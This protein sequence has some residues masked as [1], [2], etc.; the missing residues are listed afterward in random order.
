[1]KTT[2]RQLFVALVMVSLAA[3]LWANGWVNGALAKKAVTIKDQ[4]GIIETG[5][6]QGPVSTALTADFAQPYETSPVCVISAI[7]STIGFD[8]T[9]TQRFSVSM[10][11]VTSEGVTVFIDNPYPSIEYA[12]IH[13]RCVG[14]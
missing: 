7:P 14:Q 1:M 13:W 5:Q 4:Y 10:M 12:E 11:Q 2:R 8:A 6:L 3:A 9:G